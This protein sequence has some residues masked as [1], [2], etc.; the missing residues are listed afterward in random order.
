MTY[1][2]P[3]PTK[4]RIKPVYNTG[5]YGHDVVFPLLQSQTSNVQSLTPST[6][7]FHQT[8]HDSARPIDEVAMFISNLDKC[9]QLHAGNDTNFDQTFLIQPD[10]SFFSYKIAVNM[11]FGLKVSAFTSGTVNLGNIHVTI[12]EDGKGAGDTTIVDQIVDAGSSNLTATGEQI[13]AFHVDVIQPIKFTKA[14]PIKVR[15]QTE[16]EETGTNTWQVGML[17]VYPLIAPA[18]AKQ[19]LLSQVEVHAHA[20]LD[21]AFPIWRDETNQEKMDYSGC[22]PDGC[23]SA[24]NGIGSV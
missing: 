24:M 10:M 15:I 9:E 5:D 4:L 8:L 21:H 17:P 7:S 1:E 13:V 20:S 23:N 12:T 19:W 6:A 18:V 11:G 16:V 3:D 22:S 14:R 2:L